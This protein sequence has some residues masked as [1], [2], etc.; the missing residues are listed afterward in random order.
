MS[1]NLSPS[2]P[3]LKNGEEISPPFSPLRR[4]ARRA[5]GGRGEDVFK[6]LK[7]YDFLKFAFEAWLH[8]RII[9]DV[10][11]STKRVD[12]QDCDLLVVGLL[13]DERPLKG[14]RGW[15]DWRLNGKLSHLLIQERLTAQWKETILMPSHGR[16]T[17]RMILLLGLGKIKGY[18]YLRIREL[19]PY[20]LEILK[21]LNA[22]S[23]CLSFPYGEGYN[24]D[25]GKLAEVLLE[26]I[27]DCFDPDRKPSDGEWVDHLRLFFAERDELLPEILL[28]VQTAKSILEG[29]LKIRIVSPSG[30]GK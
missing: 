14:S 18:S 7:C 17:P 24:V 10:I 23:I 9:M 5:K 28:G 26:G 22:S 12:L 11:L 19:F 3:P 8:Y 2:N 6:L 30:E 4:L 29:R 27:A 25:S 15:V 1:G 20:L 21:N 13:E 16:I